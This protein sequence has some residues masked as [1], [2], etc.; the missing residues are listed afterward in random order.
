MHVVKVRN[1]HA[2]L[3]VG[4]SHLL[5]NGML[6]DSRNGKVIVTPHPVTTM[7]VKPDER[8]IFWKRRDANPFFHF[9]E[10]LWMLAGRKDVKFVEQF[11]KN[12]RS[13][14]D[15]GKS[16]HGA[17]GH[18]WRNF[19]PM[20]Q[21]VVIADI[22]KKNPDDRRA[23]LQMWDAKA[24]LGKEGL[25]FPCNTQIYFRVVKG[26]LDM[27]VCNRSNDIIWGAY[28]ANVVHMSM[29]QEYMAGMIGCPLGTYY[30]MSNNFHAY[31]EI[32]DKG[33]KELITDQEKCPYTS[34][35]VKPFPM[36]DGHTVPSTWL[37]DLEIFLSEGPIVGFRH[38]FFRRVV[39]PMWNSH[40]HFKT[41]SGLDKYDGASEILE[42][43][44]ASDWRLA[45]QE[46]IERRKVAYIR[47]GEKE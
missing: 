25:D 46:W 19:F 36:F 20:D 42:Q 10:A 15:D 45:C 43:C 26:L 5:V 29:L 44:E 47:K 38:R 37:E 9:F 1:A 28:G 17:Y 14:A 35:T 33:L 13:Y 22:L 32:I 3:E 40:R 30:Q 34:G 11:S 27:T 39:T 24:D 41:A 18:R 12:I 6:Q 8:V 2:A 16:F 21:L 4:L 23:V 7:Y 31:M